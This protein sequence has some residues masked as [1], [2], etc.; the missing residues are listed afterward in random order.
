MH[1]DA[2]PFQRKLLGEKCG[3]ISVEEGKVPEGKL[4]NASLAAKPLSQKA[5][6][7]KESWETRATM[8]SSKGDR[9][10]KKPKRQL[11]FFCNLQ[12]R[13]VFHA[14]FSFR[15]MYE[16]AKRMQREIGRAHV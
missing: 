13:E 12:A 15:L 9:Q 10:L 1:Q 6:Y 8:L 5:R 16:R 7:V 3:R 4:G 2:F 11:F 14:G